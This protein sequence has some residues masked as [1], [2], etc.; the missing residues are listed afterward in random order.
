MPVAICD[1]E[2]FFP[3][4]SLVTGPL[5]S[6]S[7]LVEAERFV[8]TVVLHDE[9]SM[10]LEPGRY[11][12]EFDEEFTEEELRDGGRVVIV[13]V[14]PALT[15]FDFFTDMTGPGQ[16]ETPD[17]LLSSSLVEAARE[18]SNADE[19]NVYFKAHIEYLQRIVDTVQQGGSA[20]LA[21]DFGSTAIKISREYPEKLFENLD[22]DWQQFAR[23]ADAGALGF[24]VPPVL[25]IILTR[26][27]RRE[28]IPAI[29]NDLRA[30]WADARTKAWDLIDRLRNAETLEEG[31]DIRR[32]LEVASRMLS[33]TPNE[34]DTRPARVL[35]DLIVG[36]VSG[37]ATAVISGGRPEVGAGVGAVGGAA[38]SVP[39]LIQ[40]LGP[41]LFGRGAFDLAKRV[42]REVS[43]SE[44]DALSRLLS[45]AERSKLGL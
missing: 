30:E 42:R 28:A 13:A 35:W 27:A 21:G 2:A 25:S 17:I 18:F 15:G 41:A 16:P 12:P 43:H 11:H 33:P 36:G 32:E 6:L 26:A 29:I 19:G 24:M 40:E 38:R 22:R 8:R 9:I 3:L 14:G 44:Y 10:A 34:I 20:L 1:A 37:A 23:E 5:T 7:E 39:P 31:R 4:R 45:D